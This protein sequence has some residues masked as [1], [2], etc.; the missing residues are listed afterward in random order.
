MLAICVD[1][2]QHPTELA[3]H[4]FGGILKSV[5]HRPHPSI[6]ADDVQEYGHCLLH[7]NTPLPFL[8]VP[9]MFQ[10]I[11]QVIE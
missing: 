2:P 3:V 10:L 5:Y 11:N 4:S 7:V 9:I 1:N 8:Q 6:M